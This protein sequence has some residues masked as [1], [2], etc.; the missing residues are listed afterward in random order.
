MLR[1][2]LFTHDDLDGAGCRIIYELAHR[3]FIKGTDY[4][5][6]NASNNNIDDLV[7]ET[8]IRN[9]V[10]KYTI[11]CFADIVASREVLEKIKNNFIE[12]HIW[13]HHRSNFFVEWVI[14]SVRIIP[15]NDMGVMQSGT[16]LIYQYFAELSVMHPYN[17][18]AK[19]FIGSNKYESFIS[20]LV[21]T[22]RSYDTYEWKET[23]NLDAKKL[24]ILFRLLGM[25]RFCKLY[26]ERLINFDDN[27][28]L[29]NAN[30][31]K[32]VDYKLES[33]QKN[34]NNI[35][36]DDIEVVNIRGL[37]VAFALKSL[38]VNIS[39]LS[40]QFLNKYPE[41][42]AFIDFSLW[43]NGTFQFRTVKDDIDLSSI[44]AIPV[45]GGGHA[46]AAGA[47]LSN[48][49]RNEILNILVNYLNQ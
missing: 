5:V 47:P 32:F 40:Y 30:D 35:S 33:E 43:N 42:D 44:I 14:P 16:S 23:N 29:I 45:G 12:I 13:D 36:I 6:I 25:D 34:I 24:E 21:D 10:D 48:N 19:P 26:L 7:N 1:S 17:K 37:K 4:L 3:D 22:I 9:D 18:H 20:L 38:G 8:I 15:E 49:V 28:E 2:I 31:L 41:F 46:K 27:L 39:E 11:I